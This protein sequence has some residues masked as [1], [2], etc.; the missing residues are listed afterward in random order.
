VGGVAAHPQSTKENQQEKREVLAMSDRDSSV[1]ATH[2]PEELSGA[3]ELATRLFSLLAVGVLALI[4]F[5]AIM[6]NY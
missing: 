3:E 5:M 1:Q 6:A 4:G 2:H